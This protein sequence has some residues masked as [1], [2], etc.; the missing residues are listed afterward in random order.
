M[1]I[2]LPCGQG[3]HS[4][5]KGRYPVTNMMRHGQPLHKPREAECRCVEP[6]CGVPKDAV[7]PTAQPVPTHSKVPNAVILPRL[8]AAVNDAQGIG[9]YPSDLARS[10]GIPLQRVTHLLRKAEK[11]GLVHKGKEEIRP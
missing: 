8:I 5:H 4:E 6:G 9:V 10:L 11:D 7:V 1:G 3:R 2:C